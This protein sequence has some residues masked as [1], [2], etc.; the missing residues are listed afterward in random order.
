MRWQEQA[1]DLAM[2]TLVDVSLST[3]SWIDDRRVLDV[4]KE[5]LL[6][7]AHGVQACGDE[8]AIYTFTSRR[9]QRVNIKRI[10]AFDEPVSGRTERRIAALEPGL[11]TRMGAAIR[12]VSEQ[13]AERANRH[14]LLLVLTD[15]KPNDTDHYEGR[16]AIEDTAQA[17]REARRKGL[18]VFGVTVDA[19]A[20]QY[21][22]A[23]F[24][25]GGYAIVARPAGLANALPLLYRQLIR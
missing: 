17:V 3:D 11:Y 6:V 4:E 5:A 22:P 16:F 20:R 9:R 25:R 13:L 24:G 14:R 12:H 10:K 23:I 21:F 15:G 18:T 8:H 2:A 19:E 1:R 7:L